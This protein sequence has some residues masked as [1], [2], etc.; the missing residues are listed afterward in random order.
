MNRYTDPH[1]F[2]SALITIDVQNDFIRE[3]SPVFIEGTSEILAKLRQLLD[4]YRDKQQLIIHVVRFYLSDG[5]NA[6]IC[7]KAMIEDGR[8]ILVPG[9]WG[10]DLSQEIKPGAFTRL[11]PQKLL[12]GEF[13]KIGEN[14]YVMYKPRWGAFYGTSLEEFLRTR[15]MDTLVFSGC[16]YP[17]CPRTSIYE[18]SERDFRIVLARDAMSQTYQKGEEEM[19]N[20]GVHL[21]STQDIIKLMA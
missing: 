13:Q 14:E 20:I 7:R 1:F 5:S 8:E 19:S 17:N 16:N 3:D 6:D 9:T 10:A 11:D 18:A 12:S 2:A 15:N 21:L 4:C